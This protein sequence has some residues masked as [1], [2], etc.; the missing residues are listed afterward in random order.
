MNYG[1]ENRFNQ[2]QAFSAFS[3]Q[4]AFVSASVKKIWGGNIAP[5][6]SSL[7]D[8]CFIP[9]FLLY[10]LTDFVTR[11]ACGFVPLWFWCGVAFGIC[12]V[13]YTVHIDVDILLLSCTACK[14]VSVVS[15]ICWV[16]IAPWWI[17][18]RDVW[19]PLMFF[20]PVL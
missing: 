10:F 2:L 12:S 8:L 13:C 4:A 14:T 7:R 20:T 11:G 1:L 15:K 9:C 18:H 17:F 6:G 3:L 16:S 5:C 19:S